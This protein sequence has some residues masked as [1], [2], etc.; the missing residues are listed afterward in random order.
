MTAAKKTQTPRKKV[1]PKKKPE[2]GVA[3]H[4]YLSADLNQKLR[5]HC[6]EKG[7]SISGFI[8]Q[9]LCDYFDE[10]H[11]KDSVLKKLDRQYHKFESIDSNTKVLGEAF[12]LFLRFY[13]SHTVDLPE[14]E[15]RPAWIS[16]GDK[17][18][19]FVEY[20]KKN[21]LDGRRFIDEFVEPVADSDELRKSL[22][23]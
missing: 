5:L 19:K 15:K 9:V 17:Y 13:F 11:D 2:A 20:L 22:R 16:G 8:E 14:D 6:A 12:G 21:M 10:L 1:I 18:M 3:V 7:Y 4:P 23:E